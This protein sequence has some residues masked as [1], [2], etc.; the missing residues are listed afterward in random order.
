YQVNLKTLSGRRTG[1]HVS[2]AV[3]YESRRLLNTSEDKVLNEYV[4]LAAAEAKPYDRQKLRTL[5]H[6]MSGLVP[7]KNWD[8][9]WVKRHNVLK[10]R[11]T[12]LDPKRGQNF[13]AENVSE[14][15]DMLESLDNEYG[16]I[17]SKHIWNM[18]EKG[19]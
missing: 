12:G 4:N 7:G 5:A 11:A 8:Y 16:E 2:R 17:P 19:I 13:T 18:D 14:F 6:D 10:R 1:K 15:F 9:R 3:A